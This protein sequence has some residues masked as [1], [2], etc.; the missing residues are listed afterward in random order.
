MFK[1]TVLKDTMS[2][3]LYVSIIMKKYFNKNAER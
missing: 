3:E 2:K 1:G